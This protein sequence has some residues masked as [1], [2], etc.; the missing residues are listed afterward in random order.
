ME[1][2]DFQRCPG[3]PQDRL[4]FACKCQGRDVEVKDVEPELNRSILANQQQEWHGVA[5]TVSTLHSLESLAKF[6][7]NVMDSSQPVVSNME[8]M[9]PP[10][11]RCGDLILVV[12]QKMNEV[13]TAME[14]QQLQL[15]DDAVTTGV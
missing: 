11:P 3:H 12:Q 2:L 14:S 7:R 8:H 6:H 1:L 13:L 5:S 4:F 10:E 9:K 15:I